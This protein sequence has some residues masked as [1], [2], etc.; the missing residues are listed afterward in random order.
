[1]MCP[2]KQGEQL[3]GRGTPD[4]SPAFSILDPHMAVCTHTH[5]QPRRPQTSISSLILQPPT[6]IPLA[7]RI[8]KRGCFA[9]APFFPRGWPSCLLPLF[10]KFL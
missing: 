8:A 5:T 6:E 1:M 10:W 3:G 2:G 9:Q 4:A 7:Q